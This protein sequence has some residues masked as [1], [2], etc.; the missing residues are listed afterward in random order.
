MASGDVNYWIGGF[1]GAANTW[2][3]AGNWSLGTVPVNGEK[4]WITGAVSTYAITAGLNQSAVTL[5]ELNIVSDYTGSTALIGTA[6]AYLQIGATIVNIGL[7]SPN[8]T[9]AGSGRIKLDLGSVASRIA[10]FSTAG[11]GV[12]STNVLEPVRII[13]TSASN[14][15]NIHDGVVGVA[16]TNPSEQSTLDKVTVTGGRLNCGPR[17]ALD[18]IWNKGGTIT[19]RSGI[20][21]LYNY[22]GTTTAYGDAAIATSYAYGGNIIANNRKGSGSEITTQYMRGGVLDVSQNPEPIAIGTLNYRKGQLIQSQPGQISIVTDTVLDFDQNN[23]LTLSA[24]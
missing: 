3:T 1:S 7:P 9:G 6:T 21:V 2:S 13:G 18:E 15:L 12:D 16:M 17:V 10:V 5:A 22:S 8:G 14:I 19:T 20:T 24:S 11:S 23:Q 4:V